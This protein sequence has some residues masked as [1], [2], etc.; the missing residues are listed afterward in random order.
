[1]VEYVLERF[2]YRLA[3]SPLGRRSAANSTVPSD[4]FSAPRTARNPSSSHP[5]TMASTLTRVTESWSPE[6]RRV[7]AP[8]PF[9]APQQG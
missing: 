8:S 1:M 4:P 2:L 7:P 6:H 3:T 5:S 9:V